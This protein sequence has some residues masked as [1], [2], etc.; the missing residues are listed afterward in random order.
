MP[1]ERA[2]LLAAQA[3]PTRADAPIGLGML[4]MQIGR[5][6]EARSL[7]DAEF[8]ADP[9]NVRADNMMKVLKHM[10]SYTPV[11]T[12]HY[13]VLVDP[14]QDT[15]LGK[16][17][18]RYLESVYDELTGRFGYAPPGKTRIE[19]MKNHQ[20]F[21]GRTIGLPFIPT[22]GACTGK[23]VALAS[24]RSTRQ[25]VQL[26]PRAQARGRPRHHAA[27]DRVQHPPLVHRGPGRRERGLSPAPGVEQDA[28]G[29]GAG[30]LQAAQPGHDQPRLHPP[31][32]ARRPA[33]GLLPGPALRPVHAQAVRRRR[34]DQDAHGLSPR[35]SRPIGPSRSASR[36]TRPTSRR[37]ISP[38]STRW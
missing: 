6:T 13:S 2:F 29:A 36:W 10:A 5:E 23:V 20:W 24:P 34:A 19:I 37:P 12:Q 4:Y 31:Q 27:A 7:F 38:I 26:G 17:M 8:A 25:A 30:A 35:A 18:A 33:D 9:F 22:V 3:D 16:Y 14:T 28:P 32:R 21:S 11:E 1:A 15:L